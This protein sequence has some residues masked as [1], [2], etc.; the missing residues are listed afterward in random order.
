QG[1]VSLRQ[2][3]MAPR[4]ALIRDIMEK[5]VVAVKASDDREVVAKELARYDLIAIPVLDDSGRMVGIVTHD[6]VIDVV[7]EEATEDAYRMGAV[8]P[9]EEHY[10]EANFVTLWRKRAF[11][12]ACLFVAELATFNALAYFEN[13]IQRMVV[14]SLF[15]PLCISTGGNS[16]SQA[17]TL[18]TRA[19][20]L[21]QVQLRDWYRVFRHEMFM[22]LALG[23]T[24]GVIGFGRALMTSSD[25]R[26]EVPL[27]ELA[28][29]IAQTVAF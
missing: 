2:L 27:L 24:L 13:E 17:A 8:A 1:V 22:G 7:V 26:G 11:W 28:L 23:G 3:I 20:A 14:L 6:D 16:G 9:M 25:V 10:L 12:L 4:H 29:V 18:I 15:I 19:M 5:Q 21:G